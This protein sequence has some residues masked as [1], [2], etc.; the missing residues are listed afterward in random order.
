M[1]LCAKKGLSYEKQYCYCSILPLASQAFSG[2]FAEIILP[3]Y[4]K[5]KIRCKKARSEE[6][7]EKRLRSGRSVLPSNQTLRKNAIP[8]GK[9][10]CKETTAG[11]SA[12]KKNR[13]LYPFFPLVKRKLVSTMAI[14]ASSVRVSLRTTE[15]HFR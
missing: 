3:C 11:H 8:S 10:H 7:Q 1:P 2:F 12:G 9:P 14:M 4:M 6:K 5:W 15:I 13:T